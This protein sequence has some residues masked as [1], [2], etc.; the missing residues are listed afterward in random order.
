[1]VPMVNFNISEL[2][3][4]HGRWMLGGPHHPHLRRH[5]GV[6]GRA[7]RTVESERASPGS[8]T[9]SAER[10]A[11]RTSARTQRATNSE[12]RNTYRSMARASGVP[13]STFRQAERQA[14][15]G[16]REKGT[17]AE[18]ASR[19]ASRDRRA[20]NRRSG[21]HRRYHPILRHALYGGGRH[22]RLMQGL[23]LAQ[24]LHRR[25]KAPPKPK[26]KP[27]PKKK[28]APKAKVKKPMAVKRPRT[29]KPPK[30]PTGKRPG[31]GAGKGGGVAQKVTPSAEVMANLA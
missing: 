26:K 25:K 1:M 22:G 6:I 17:D 28:V 5:K 7:I 9:R 12:I 2:R 31:A 13:D 30:A 20:R 11:A 21:Y 15:V 29:I 24:L 27:A 3:G 4:F 10:A 14:G 16:S 18:R 23:Y 19:G 8:T